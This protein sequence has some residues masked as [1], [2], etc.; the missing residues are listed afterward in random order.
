VKGGRRRYCTQPAPARRSFQ[1]AARTG[2]TRFPCP[3][4]P[5]R[6]AMCPAMFPVVHPPPSHWSSRLGKIF[7]KLAGRSRLISRGKS[8]RDLEPAGGWP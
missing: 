7:S 1:R 8:L 3:L 6:R 2:C 5:D 4:A